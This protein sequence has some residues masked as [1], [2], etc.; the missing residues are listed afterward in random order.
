MSEILQQTKISKKKKK[1]SGDYHDVP[2][3]YLLKTGNPMAWADVLRPLHL[4]L[5]S[6][7]VN[8]ELPLQLSRQDP[9]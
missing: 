6:D 4:L 9:V 3:G 1:N 5:M 8:H 2:F 7:L